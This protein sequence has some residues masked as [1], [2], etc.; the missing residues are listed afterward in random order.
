MPQCIR[1]FKSTV[2][3]TPANLTR[4]PVLGGFVGQ[5]S[6]EGYGYTSINTT[7]A[8][9]MD[10]MFST[11]RLFSL[12]CDK[13][14]AATGTVRSNAKKFLKSLA[15]RGKK[16]LKRPWST[17]GAALCEAN[18]VLALTWM[19]NG[20]VQMLTTLHSVGP[21]HTVE[22]PR[23]RP[24]V[25]STNG[26]QIRQVFGASAVKT[27]A[28][29]KVVDDYNLFVRGVDIVDQLRAVYTC[30]LPSRRTWLPL[31]FCFLIAAQQT[32]QNLHSS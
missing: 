15:I 24:R 19:D 23:K 29:P 30:H 31:F 7:Y 2:Q 25:T 16:G 13:D 6:R 8:I 12:L 4:N 26:A 32:F 9:L 18:S 1:A 14:I 3:G 10:N 20:A 11:P 5:E 28:I 21:E 27:L 17:L 22:R